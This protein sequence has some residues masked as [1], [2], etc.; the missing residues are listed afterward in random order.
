M[1]IA[2]IQKLTLLDYPGRTAATLFTPGCNFRCPFCHNGELVAPGI[3]AQALPD[4]P[5]EEVLAFLKKR[6]GLL[7]GVCL[8]GG[9]PLLQPDIA[10]FC[11]TLH[12]LEFAVKLDTNGTNPVL[13]RKLLDAGLIDYVAMDVKN[14]PARYAETAGVPGLS[15]EP[16]QRTLDWLLSGPVD[17]ELRT[18]VVREFHGEDDILA[19]AEW[20]A[21][22]KRWYL[23]AF[24]DRD[25]VL[26]PGLTSYSK[27][28]MERLAQAA[29]R[30]VPC[31][32]VRGI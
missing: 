13:L 2:G 22:A 3:S 11:E 5:L 32:E 17:S 4:L 30:F 6:S 21:G 7:D 12:A 8:S 9:E 19:L 18:T 20:I 23:Q 28:E 27:E 15:L 1:R 25:T 31:A 24:V 16:V 10:E 29:R 14:C 26:R